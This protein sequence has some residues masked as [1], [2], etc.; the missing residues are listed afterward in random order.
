MFF[1]YPIPVALHCP[2]LH[3]DDSIWVASVLVTP[4]GTVLQLLSSNGQGGPF[5][6][7][8][9]ILLTLG[10][11]D[12][13]FPLSTSLAVLPLRPSSLLCLTSQCWR[14]PGCCPVYPPPHFLSAYLSH[15]ICSRALNANLVQRTLKSVPVSITLLK[16]IRLFSLNPSSALSLGCLI[17]I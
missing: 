16:N 8:L 9:I 11:R 6:L 3:W 17:G 14:A 1:S 7:I 5:L 15:F 2:P 12:F 10:F 4:E 13:V